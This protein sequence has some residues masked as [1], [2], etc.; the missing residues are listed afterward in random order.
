MFATH[1]PFT[2][3]VNPNLTHTRA[4]FTHGFSGRGIKALLNEIK[5]K[6]CLPLGFIRKITQIIETRANEAKGLHKEIIQVFG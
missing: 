3:H 1:P 6:P 4:N 2:Q 5:F